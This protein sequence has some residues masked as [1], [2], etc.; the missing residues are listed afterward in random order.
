[1]GGDG[2][3]LLRAESD[4]PVAQLRSK[5]NLARSSLARRVPKDVGEGVDWYTETFIDVA[6][7]GDVA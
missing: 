1:M 7:A 6:F 5:G 4:T 2:Y 3:A